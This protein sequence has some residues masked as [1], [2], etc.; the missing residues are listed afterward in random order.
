MTGHSSN[1]AHRRPRPSGMDTF[2]GVGG[3]G[4]WRWM[5]GL[6]RGGVVFGRANGQ[7]GAEGAGTPSRSPAPAGAPI[8]SLL[9]HRSIPSLCPAPPHLRYWEKRMMRA[10]VVNPRWGHPMTPGKPA[11]NRARLWGWWGWGWGGQQGEEEVG[12]DGGTHFTTSTA[13][14]GP[15]QREPW[16]TRT[17]MLTATV[18]GLMARRTL[19]A[20]GRGGDVHQ[21]AACRSAGADCMG[22]PAAFLGPAPQK[23]DPKT[24]ADRA[25]DAERADPKHDEPAADDAAADDAHCVVEAVALGAKLH[26]G[27]D[28]G[29]DGCGEGRGWRARLSTWGEV[30]R[31]TSL[32]ARAAQAARGA[33]GRRR[34]VR[35]LTESGADE[36]KAAALDNGQAVAE[37]RL[38]GKG[39][40]QRARQA[41][42]L[43]ASAAFTRVSA[44]PAAG[45]GARGLSPVKRRS[46][47]GQAPVKRPPRARRAPAAA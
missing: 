26:G 10:I 29:G 2:L 46:S 35:R 28:V 12:G 32:P 33:G 4:W 47:A 39:G 31:R 7:G 30:A 25:N 9:P 41:A 22:I 16:P 13:R 11:E 37:E 18:M 23:P 19:G 14:P 5:V 20:A 45:R 15:S 43:D 27:L 17:A 6:G 8:G 38:R 1:S 34:R 21:S 24:P 44:R 36:G 3:G 40:G 42:A